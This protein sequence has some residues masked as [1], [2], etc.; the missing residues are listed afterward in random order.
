MFSSP[1]FCNK[2][3]ATIKCEKYL[4]QLRNRLASQENSV[5]WRSVFKRNVFMNLLTEVYNCNM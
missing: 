2:P 1:K 3:P 5:P 4:V